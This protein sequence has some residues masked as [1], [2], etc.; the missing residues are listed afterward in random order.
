MA[1]GAGLEGLARQP[2]HA[3]GWSSRP[4]NRLTELVPVYK[5]NRDEITT[6]Y[7]MNALG[8]IG[9]LKWI[10]SGSRPHRLHDAVNMVEQNRG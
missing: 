6:Q 2:T 9:L 5:T 8:G 4:R 10:S 1:V 7:D 3:A